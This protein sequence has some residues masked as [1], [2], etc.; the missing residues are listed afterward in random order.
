MERRKVNRCLNFIK[1]I[2][3][4]GVVY[5]HSPFPNKL[6]NI[7]SYILKFAVPVFFMI[8]G[9]F[10]YYERKDD[11]IDRLPKKI[12]H[13]LKLLVIA[14]LVYAVEYLIKNNGIPQYSFSEILSKIFV[15]TFFNGTL[16]FLYALVWSYVLLYFIYKTG[17]EKWFYY[18]AP[19][20]LIVHVISRIIIKNQE[21]YNVYFYR[22]FLMYGLPFVLMGSYIRFN[23]KKIKSICSNKICISGI[24]IGELIMM[25]EWFLTKTAVDIYIGTIIA[26][27]YI[28]IFAIMNP[29]K[30]VNKHFEFIGAK[31]SMYVYIIHLFAIE[32]ASEYICKSSIMKYL[33]PIIAIIISLIFAY[34]I[35]FIVKMVRKVRKKDG[36]KN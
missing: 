22:N 33:V 12:I 28:F 20:I 10:S 16:W 21:W 3:C 8:S 23:E 24:I 17:K 2:C 4:I 1:A 7:V 29:E 18:M 30:Y 14:E 32:I 15:G 31:L 25:G 6:G 13:I 11:R 26:S 34:I 35:D 27:L 36:L 19:I 9:Y 5:M